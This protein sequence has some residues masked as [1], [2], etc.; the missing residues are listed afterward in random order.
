[1]YD[2]VSS[3]WI[4]QCLAHSKH[5]FYYS[6]YKCYRYFEVLVVDGINLSGKK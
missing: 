6:H 5:L 2:Y 3:S 1:M 4:L